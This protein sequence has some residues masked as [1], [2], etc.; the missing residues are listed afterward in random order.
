MSLGRKLLKWIDPELFEHVERMEKIHS[1]TRDHIRYAL[2]PV[3]VT[4]G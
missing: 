1:V 2:M 3:E 4:N